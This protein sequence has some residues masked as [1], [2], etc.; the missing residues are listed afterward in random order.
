MTFPVRLVPYAIVVLVAG[1]L[2]SM[3]W[4]YVRQR[5]RAAEERGR[6]SVQVRWDS[7][8]VVASRAAVDSALASVD[9]QARRVDTVRL[10]VINRYLPASNASLDSMRRVVDSLGASG[11]D[12]VMRA[13]LL[14]GIDRA[15]EANRAC[16]ELAVSC[17]ALRDT[18]ATLRPAFAS[19]RSR[20]D[21]L[22]TSSRRVGAASSRQPRLSLGLGGAV[23]PCWTRDGFEPVCATAGLSG[24]IPL[25]R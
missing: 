12:S 19:L 20:Y 11:L 1:W 25:R 18:L 3:G 5:E 6:S 10:Q 7:V 21:S 17:G 24:T 14:R 8:A 13:M 22:V 2:A 15:G 4:I 23:G 9:R 16:N